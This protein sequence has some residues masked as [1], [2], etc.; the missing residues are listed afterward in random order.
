M[1]LGAPSALERGSIPARISSS[2]GI[3]GNNMRAPPA[4]G[5]RERLFVLVQCPTH[6]KPNFYPCPR[7]AQEPRAAGFPCS[8][9]RV[10]MLRCNPGDRAAPTIARYH[11]S[12]TGRTPGCTPRPPLGREPGALLS[13]PD[14]VS[15]K[16]EAA[17]VKSEA[18]PVKSEAAPVK[19]EAARGGRLPL[20]RIYF[21]AL[22]PH[23]PL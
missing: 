14:A 15:E 6:S 3:S 17:P 7:P 18:A 19:S 12:R 11:L 2:Q 4:A 16:S 8:G 22:L 10:A 20:G 13:S 5:C 1:R 21:A 9:C 23:C